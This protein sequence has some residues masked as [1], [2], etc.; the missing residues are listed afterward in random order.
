MNNEQHQLEL[1]EKY[2]SQCTT[3]EE[4]V[5]FERLMSDDKSF[6]KSYEEMKLLVTGIENSARQSLWNDLK[7]LDATLP[8]IKP[9]QDKATH[10]KTLWIKVSFAIAASVAGIIFVINLLTPAGVSNGEI[11]NRYYQPYGSLVDANNRSNDKSVT[12]KDEALLL[13][14]RG[15]YSGAIQKLS[16][17]NKAEDV[18]IEFYLASAYMGNGQLK[19]AEDKFK[20]VLTHESLFTD[21]AKWYLAL[22]YIK[23]NQLDKAKLIFSELANYENAYMK[24]AK[25]ILHLAK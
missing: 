3:K 22:C 21:Q 17:L 19:D 15:N 14:T 18:E 10:G 1:I 23:T 7:I 2:I 13:Y 20:Q 16:L 12:A 25:E 9:K 6:G 24:N 8:E 5:E 11:Y 4:T